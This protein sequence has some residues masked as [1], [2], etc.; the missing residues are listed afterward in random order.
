MWKRNCGIS[1]AENG[2]GSGF[3]R[4]RL[5]P[6]HST[7]NRIY[8]H[9]HTIDTTKSIYWHCHQKNTPPTKEYIYRY[10]KSCGYYSWRWSRS[11]TRS[12]AEGQFSSARGLST[13]GSRRRICRTACGNNCTGMELDR[14]FLQDGRV[15]LSY[16]CQIP[17]HGI[18]NRP[19]HLPSTGLRTHERKPSINSK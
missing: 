2:Q 17:W 12:K 10:N 1:I 5:T 8:T 15:Q 4:R 13:R 6:L 14:L 9:L 11:V 18:I 16:S 7:L 19:Q 3:L